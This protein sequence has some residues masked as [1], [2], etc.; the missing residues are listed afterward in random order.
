M[1]LWSVLGLQVIPKHK[2]AP[3]SNGLLWQRKKAKS[4]HSVGCGFGIIFQRKK[5]SRNISLHS[6]F[7]PHLNDD[8]HHSGYIHFAN[9]TTVIGVVVAMISSTIG[10]KGYTLSVHPK[11]I[12]PTIWIWLFLVVIILFFLIVTL[13]ISCTFAQCEKSTLSIKRISRHKPS[14]KITSWHF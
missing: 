3:L 5:K 13:C 4:D 6:S 2:L 8:N 12:L 9:V 10:S 11:G 14:F 1:M 7:S